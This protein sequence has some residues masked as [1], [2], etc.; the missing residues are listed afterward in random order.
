ML[1]SSR[2]MRNS[3]YKTRNLKM[4]LK[5]TQTNI[6]FLF[7]QVVPSLCLHVLTIILLQRHAANVILS[8]KPNDEVDVS[9]VSPLEGLLKEGSTPEDL[10][11]MLVSLGIF[12]EHETLE[13]VL[14]PAP[15]DFSE[16]ML[17]AAREVAT[18]PPQDE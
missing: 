1:T 4:F 17:S 2:E 14:H 12:S 9:A 10:F 15:L 8:S 13:A 5:S 16:D 7:L 3:P 11:K 18:N 6:T